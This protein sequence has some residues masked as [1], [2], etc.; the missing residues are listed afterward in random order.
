MNKEY[1]EP[2]EHDIKDCPK[3][4]YHCG[5][6]NTPIS[7]SPANYCSRPEDI[8]NQCEYCKVA[9]PTYDPRMNLEVKEVKP[10][11]KESYLIEIAERIVID[12]ANFSG[13]EDAHRAEFRQEVI[14]HLTNLLQ[15]TKE[16][17]RKEIVI[18]AAIRMS[19]GYIVRGHR[20]CDAI[21]T[22]SKIPRYKNESH[23]FGDDQGFVTSLN[24]YVNRIEGA[25]LQKAAGIKSKM[26][27]G[28]EY[29]HGELYSED[30][31]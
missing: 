24:R 25:K 2:C 22:A 6:C 8:P 31:Y 18:C 13:R 20:H 4:K 10:T 23:R 7:Y 11:E 3:H 27:E 26:P 12:Y 15:E 19:D 29:L 16:A 1:Q 30:L 21:L 17:T 5:R 9:T 14:K 28:Q